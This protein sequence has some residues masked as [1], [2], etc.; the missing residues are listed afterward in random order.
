LDTSKNILKSTASDLE[1]YFKSTDFSKAMLLGIALTLPIIAGV[2]LELLDVGITITVGAMLAS[3]S[4]VSGSI[5]HKTKGLLL[6]T[7]LAMAI[8][9]IGGY[10]HFSAWVLFPILGILIFGISYISI[11]GFRASLISFTG[12][13]ALVLS[14]SNVSTDLQ[15][16][17][18]ALLIGLGGIWYI[19][20]AVVWHYIYPKG[21][22][23]YYLSKTLRLTAD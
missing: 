14:F 11:Y 23:E 17:E 8:S 20:L 5:K 18:K 2:K 12:L 21:Q 7:F 9:L 10:L 16:Y 3:P 6:A 22:T 19:S 13:F 4:D 15:P 1:E